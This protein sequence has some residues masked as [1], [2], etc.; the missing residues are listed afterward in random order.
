M[1][2]TRSH[3]LLL[4]LTLV[5]CLVMAAGCGAQT[6]S[7]S[8]GSSAESQAEGNASTAA[9]QAT[10]EAQQTS[11]N[12][13]TRLADSFL[14]VQAQ[15]QASSSNTA[16]GAEQTQRAVTDTLNAYTGEVGVCVM[17]FDGSEAF[18]IN[19][20][21]KFVSA[22]MIKLLIL[23]EFMA[24]VDAGTI[25]LSDTYTLQGSD[26]V[27]GTGVIGD[28]GAGT[29]YT[30][31]QLAKHMIA[32]SD[33]TATNIL[34][35]KLG[36]AKINARAITLGL[37]N[38][39]LQRKMMDTA[40]GLENH[41]S[42]NDAVVILKGIANHNIASQQMCET[43]LGYL[44]AQTD[45]EGLAQTIPSGIE[46]PHKTGTLNAERHDAGIV[47]SKTPYLIAVFTN[48]ISSPN[49]LLANISNTV[50]NGY[51]S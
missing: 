28:A 17:R 13:L 50:Y 29:S 49:S 23:C 18:Q 35:D 5:F 37:S 26:I 2:H 38:T 14:G 42:A 22:S 15:D 45:N 8:Q 25:K 51:S 9:T 21:E 20:N 47:Y 43:A 24:Q 6:Q 1:Q 48:D 19:G 46:F 41:M 16:G 31:D 7:T 10:G 40:S 36:M 3:R 39:D 27:G 11:G 34:I 30:Y 12:P 44:K 32:E 4:A 33:N